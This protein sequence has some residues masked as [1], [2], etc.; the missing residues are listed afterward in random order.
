MLNW[1]RPSAGFHFYE[2]PTIQ[3]MSSVSQWFINEGM[4]AGIPNPKTRERT[5]TLYIDKA[6]FKTALDIQDEQHITLLL[7]DRQGNVLWRQQGAYSPEK[8]ALLTQAVHSLLT[9]PVAA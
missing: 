5:I 7:V 1:K 9:T 6:A 3:R 4:R 8:A 2:L